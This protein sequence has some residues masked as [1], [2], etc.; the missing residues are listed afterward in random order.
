MALK[1]PREMGHPGAHRLS[2]FLA[3]RVRK[4]SKTSEKVISECELCAQLKPP[5]FVREPTIPLIQSAKP[6]S[7]ISIDFVGPKAVSH[8]GCRWIFTV[9]DEYS[10]YPF[11]FALPEITTEAAIQCLT[12]LFLLFGPP[13]YVHS[14]RG[15]Q[16]ESNKFRTFLDSWNIG[17]LRTT[18]YHPSG[19]GHVERFNGIIWQTVSLQL[20]KK[21]YRNYS[22]KT[23]WHSRH[24]TSELSRLE[25]S[26][27]RHHMPYFFCSLEGPQSTRNNN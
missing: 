19:N 9:V 25:L 14:D 18:P 2:K 17:K 15:S 10:R 21:T 3:P 11:A 4:L 23:N 24:Q 13:S 1:L 7:R 12:N 6:W 5:R 22:G 27:I 20:A 26:T 16:F 8:R